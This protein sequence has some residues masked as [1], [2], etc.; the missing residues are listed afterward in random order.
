RD[1]HQ[2]RRCQ[3]DRQRND[4]EDRGEEGTDR[5]ADGFHG[6]VSSTE[7]R[8]DNRRRR[9]LDRNS[10][11][12][13]GSVE[14]RQIAKPQLTLCR[15]TDTQNDDSRAVIREHDSMSWPSADSKV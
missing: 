2:Q 5:V 15:M 1:Q 13:E 7:G 14:L 9:L 6:K 8:V 11:G 12:Y 3:L 4:L 10:A